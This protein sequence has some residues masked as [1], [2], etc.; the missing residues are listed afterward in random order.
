MLL[1]IFLLI[2]WAAAFPDGAP[3][4]ACGNQ[5]PSHS[6]QTRPDTGGYSIIFGAGSYMAGGSTVTV[7]IHVATVGYR[8]LLMS[9]FNSANQR[10]GTFDTTLIPPLTLGVKVQC[11]GPGSGTGITHVS[12]NLKSSET[13]TWNPPVFTGEGTLNFKA[14]IVRSFEVI[15]TISNTL[16]ETLPPGPTPSTPP[17]ELTFESSTTSTIT[18]SWLP[19]ADLGSLPFYSYQLW[20]STN[21]DIDYVLAEE[22]TN[23]ATLQTTDTGLAP[24]TTYYYSI[25]AITGN[26][27][28][29]TDVEG[30][31]SDPPIAAFTTGSTATPA[32]APQFLQADSSTTTS[33]FLTWQI[34]ASFGSAVF[35]SYELFRGDLHDGAFV[36]IVNVTDVGILQYNDTGLMPGRP[37]FYKIR[38]L[39]LDGSIYVPGAFSSVESGSTLT[40]PEPT[41]SDA[42]LDFHIVRR[43]LYT[44]TTG[45]LPPISL[46]SAPFYSYRVYRTRANP[47]RSQSLQLIDL[48]DIDPSV[49]FLVCEILN[50]DEL[51]CADLQLQAGNSYSYLIQV[52]TR[53][54]GNSTDILGLLSSLLRTSTKSLKPGSG[55]KC[56]G[57]RPCCGG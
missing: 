10:V 46:G 45:W 42:P 31:F 53:E 7:E 48:Q 54:S 32:T 43:S 11:F 21:P 44:I 9:A 49:L 36:S 52:V 20:R 5:L 2:S 38:V 30:D 26:P 40:P 51:E 17:Q 50:Y 6:A 4:S 37:Y 1:F 19:P 14:T 55:G 39:T 35:Y 22:I 57:N 47:V 23:Y 12:N 8:G 27:L 29:D 16:N 34:P 15:Y 18:L 25:R 41:R 13:F 24:S 28:N 3:T 33:I 56:C